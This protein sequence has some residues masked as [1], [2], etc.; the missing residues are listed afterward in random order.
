MPAPRSPQSLRE[1]KATKYPRFRYYVTG[2]AAML[3]AYFF[4][5]FPALLSGF[6]VPTGFSYVFSALT[7]LGLLMYPFISRGAGQL[8]KYR[9][10]VKEQCSG[11]LNVIKKGN[12]NYTGIRPGL[13][14]G[15]DVKTGEELIWENRKMVTHAMVTGTTGKGKSSFLFS[16]LCQQCLRGGGAIFIDGGKNIETLKKLI[17]ICKK[18]GRLDELRIVDP[19]TPKHG[20]TY[21]PLAGDD[22]DLI[23][24]KIQNVLNP[25]PVGSDSEYYAN[26]IY[27]ATLTMSQALQ[28]LGKSFNF[29]DVLCL[30]DSPEVSIKIL[31]DE[32]RQTGLYEPLIE[33]Q[34]LIGEAKNIQGFKDVVSNMIANLA[35]VATSDKGDF[36]CASSTDIS[37]YEAVRKGQIIYI[38]LPRMSDPARAERLGRVFLADIQATIGVF[39]EQKNFKPL[40]PYLIILDEFGSYAT[41]QFSVVFEQARKAN[42]SVVAAVQSLG[43][44]SDP[45]R[46]LSREFA[47]KVMGNTDT[48]VYFA[49]RDYETARTAAFLV[50]QEKALM[51]QASVSNGTA[52]RG[53][54]ISL[55][56]LFNP[57][58]QESEQS[59]FG[60]SEQYDFKVRPEVF[61]HDLNDPQGSVI[62]DLGTGE[63]VFAR[64]MW[65]NPHFPPGWDYEKEIPR[66]RPKQVVPLGLYERV[67]LQCYEQVV[68]PKEKE[69]KGED[70]PDQQPDTCKK[71]RAAQT[72]KQAGKKTQKAAAKKSTEEQ[73]PPSEAGTNKAETAN[74]PSD[75]LNMLD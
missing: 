60:F 19:R 47:Q 29:R 51:G 4:L 42:F 36:L 72:R 11:Q 30:F 2:G 58:V 64:V 8:K 12:G 65:S 21:N 27:H 46:G 5:D 17:W 68:N 71:E 45:D 70:R 41:P 33:V 63:P 1:V 69:T 24:N 14:L 52:D 56:R 23:A 38:M 40:I 67:Y 57:Q 3:S 74:S 34:K 37:L 28:Q 18:A 32:L 26:R 54:R 44:L 73:K 66:F 50:G 55:S 7:P 35:S 15:H 9:R 6:G 31:K 53:E 75:I 62:I 61:M 20:H 39:Y 13:T 43:N 49:V 25:T 22:P 59:S 48:K 16:L 10:H